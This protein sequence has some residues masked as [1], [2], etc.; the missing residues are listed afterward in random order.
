MIDDKIGKKY[1][2][3][4]SDLS[5]QGTSNILQ[6]D[7]SN[8]KFQSRLNRN[9]IFVCSEKVI[10]FESV[11]FQKNKYSR[12]NY[13]EI[14]SKI[15]KTNLEYPFSSDLFEDLFFAISSL[16]LEEWEIPRESDLV[17]RQNPQYSSKVYSIVI[18]HK[19]QVSKKGYFNLELN[20]FNSE[21]KYFIDDFFPDYL[22]NFHYNSRMFAFLNKGQSLKDF[23]NFMIRNGATY[24]NQIA[25]Q[26]NNEADSIYLNTGDFK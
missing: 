2:I 17:L 19:S 8:V 12:F 25:N 3:N 18:A 9:E 4:P 13:Q 11:M 14:K 6:K 10:T 20:P 7:I 21:D 16:S 1:S 22:Q 26:L 15:I 5:A 23:I 24:S